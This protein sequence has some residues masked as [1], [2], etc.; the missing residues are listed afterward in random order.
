MGRFVVSDG[1][2]AREATVYKIVVDGVVRPI[3]IA[4]GVKDGIVREYWPPSTPSEDDRIVW[5]TSPITVTRERID[6]RESICNINFNRE[7]GTAGYA[8]FPYADGYAPFLN[9][10]TSALGEYLIR[11]DQVSGDVLAGPLGSWIDIHSAADHVWQ[12]L[13]SGVGTLNAVANIS[14]SKDAG[15]GTPDASTTVVKEVT[16][17]CRV[18]DTNVISWTTLSRTAEDIKQAETADSRVIINP[19]GLAEG[20]GNT[21]SFNEYWH[22][23]APFSFDSSL[24]TVEATLVSGDT[25]SG[26]SL[27]YPFPCDQT[28]EWYLPALFDDYDLTCELDIRIDDS[29][30][31]GRGVT[32]RVTLHS[33]TG[34]ITEQ[35]SPAIVNEN[36]PYIEYYGDGTR[37]VF[38]FDW[39]MIDDSSIVVI[40]DNVYVYEWT[41]EGSAVVFQIVPP[42]N[43]VIQIFRKTKIWMP[44]NYRAMGRFNAEK[45]ELSMDRAYM[46]AQERNGTSGGDDAPN[47]EVGGADLHILR[48]QYVVSVVSDRGTNAIIPMYSPDDTVPPTP[49][50]PDP[51]ITWVGDDIISGIF[52]LEGNVSGVAARINFELDGTFDYPNYNSIVSGQWVDIDPSDNDYWMRVTTIQGNNKLLISDGENFRGSGEAF[53]VNGQGPYV[54]VDTFGDTP[55]TTEDAIVLIEISKDSGGLPDGGWAQRYVSLEAIF[56][57]LAEPEPPVPPVDPPPIDVSGA[58]SWEQFFGVPFTAVRSE[59]TKVIPAA[60]VSIWFTVPVTADVVDVRFGSIEVTSI[61]STR[62]GAL[63]TT[64]GDYTTPPNFTWGN[65]TGITGSINGFPGA[66]IELVPGNTYIWNMKLDD[67]QV[68]NWIRLEVIYKV[69]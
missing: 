7:F 22:V 23:D 2:N 46:I 8:N 16:F 62:T 58:Y 33:Q 28:R 25:P 11:V 66:D 35:G 24:F 45:T 34:E 13:Q 56:N 64:V 14:V 53:Q 65:G 30:P 43:S 17:D 44:E 61:E 27:G 31:I 67:P 52:S 26:N 12:L 10:P 60:G 29:V 6:P 68:N 41:L 18:V 63:N 15:G 48:G 3:Q 49:Q 55:P 1:A 40:Q 50:P 19:N 42:V 57:T 69:Q 47:G 20:I 9:P 51:S 37:T 38:P 54:S 36:D 39:R 5:T 4:A 32:K 59:I 21:Q